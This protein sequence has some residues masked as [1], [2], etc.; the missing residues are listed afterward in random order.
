MK[1]GEMSIAVIIAAAIA[2]LILVIMAVL[3]L[4]TS[5]QTVKG[6]GC[7]GIGGQCYSSCA[8]LGE[9][10]GGT[11]ARNLPN[12]GKD[13]GCGVDEECCVTLLKGNAE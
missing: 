1:K 10:T 9:D 6:T 13:G 11:Y 12:S 7:E 4:R 5:N 2:L 3:I 8:D